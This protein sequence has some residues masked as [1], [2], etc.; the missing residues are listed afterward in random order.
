M[1]SQLYK[2]AGLVIYLEAS[3]AELL[4][5]TSEILEKWSVLPVDFTDHSEKSG[6]IRLSF[7][8]P[9]RHVKSTLKKFELPYGG[10]CFTDGVA[11]LIKFGTCFV[12]FAG[13]SPEADLALAVEETEDLERRDFT[14]ALSLAF[15]AVLRRNGFY[16][17]HAAALIDPQEKKGVLIAAGT[18]N[19]KSTLT[20][21][22]ASRGWK[23]L[24]DDTVVLEKHNDQIRAWSLIRGFGLRQRTFDLMCQILPPFKAE[25]ISGSE[26]KIRVAPGELFPEQYEESCI[27]TVIVFPKINDKDETRFRKLSQAETMKLL[28]KVCPWA[29]YDTPVAVYYLTMLNQL[30][31]QCVGYELESGTDL[32]DANK[33]GELFSSFN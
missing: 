20:L 29:G 2:L 26:N 4:S 6:R 32:L 22:L 14:L 1:Q 33:V 9:D 5:Y 27:A 11:Y 7:S 18:N 24:S 31:R 30:S 23:Y 17:L 10:E 28:L 16:E 12:S 19:G 21:L 13:T 3:N 25:K 8:K 15:Q